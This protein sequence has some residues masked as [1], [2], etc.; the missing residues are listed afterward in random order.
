MSKYKS[1][2]D[3]FLSSITETTPR[4]NIPL[5]IFDLIY[6]NIYCSF[7]LM[8]LKNGGVKPCF[9]LFSIFFWYNTFDK[10]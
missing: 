10:C 6:F 4:G 2:P 1:S 9:F 5:G 3:C 8:Y 7:C